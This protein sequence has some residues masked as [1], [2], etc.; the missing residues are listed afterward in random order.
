MNKSQWQ[1]LEWYRGCPI[2]HRPGMQRRGYRLV[3]HN[4][5]GIITMVHYTADKCR[6]QCDR[7]HSRLGGQVEVPEQ[8]YS[9]WK[10]P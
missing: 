3:Y 4:S 6:H 9:E 1:L 5:V 7:L 8:A 10:Q 2:E